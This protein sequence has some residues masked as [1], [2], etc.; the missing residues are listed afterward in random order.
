MDPIICNGP[1]C[2]S[3]CTKCLSDANDGTTQKATDIID[4]LDFPAVDT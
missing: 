4:E 1:L 2:N 3:Q